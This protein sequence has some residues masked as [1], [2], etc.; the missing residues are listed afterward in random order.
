MPV[1]LAFALGVLL[2]QQLARLPPL[3]LVLAA[4]V[5]ALVLARRLPWLGALLVGLGYASLHAHVALASPFP[6]VWEMKDL[7]AEGRVLSLPDPESGRTR[8]LFQI[9]ELRSDAGPIEF[10]GRVRLAWHGESRPPLRSGEGWTLR[11]RLKRPHG[12]L[13]PGLFDYEGWLWREGIQST[14]YVRSSAE[15]RR[16][17]VR[18]ATLSLDPWRQALGEALDRQ[19]PQAASALI[20]ALTIGDGSGFTPEQWEDFRRTGTNHVISI[21]GLHVG[22]A[23]GLLLL[24]TER[25]WRLSPTLCLWLAA[26]R[27]GALAGMLGALFYTALAGFLVPTQRSLIMIIA[28]LLPRLLAREVRPW[29]GLALALILVLLIDPRAVMSPSF[30]LSY[31]AVAAIFWGMAGWRERGRFLSLVRVQWVIL[32]LITPLT[33]S[34]FHQT[35]LLAFPINL[36]AVPVFSLL[37]VPAALVGV[38]A[39]ALAPA[40][41]LWLFDRIAPLYTLSIEALHAA[42]AVDTG[43]L[44]LGQRPLA[45]LLLATLGAAWLAFPLRLPGHYLAPLLFLPFILGREEPLADGAFEVR[46]LDVGQGL[47]V[48]VRTAHHLLLYDA[49]PSYPDGLDA[50]EMIVVPALRALGA[51]RIDRLL[52]SHPSADHAGGVPSVIRSIPVTEV[53]GD[54]GRGIAAKPCRAGESWQWDGVEFRL[55]HPREGETWDEN[56]GSCVLAVANGAGQLLLTGD[57]ERAGEE[58]LLDRYGAQLQSRVVQAGHHGSRTSSSPGFVQATAPRAALIANG[59][60]NRFGFPAAEV[61]RRWQGAGAQ[62]LETA[63]SGAIRFRF[64]PGG[65]LEGP[66][67]EREQQARFWR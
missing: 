31:A 38:L 65:R 52:A 40:A 21:S 49:G 33:L 8:F 2:T 23:A 32:L 27:A 50:G 5:L 20:K 18:D 44:E 54:P 42:A 28:L 12:L 30:L 60:R 41:G 48:V 11:V 63:D 25:L 57:L 7:T 66:V 26:P 4:L 64:H 36:L 34:L 58:A 47:A 55:L 22:L 51:N 15:N 56:N 14:G 45:T 24:L 62:V 39:Y 3:P 19:L 1:A 29:R 35:S 17:P 61:V 13:N 46:M 16:L 43:M 37:L 53:L 59:Y 6:L 10:R 9:E 67:R